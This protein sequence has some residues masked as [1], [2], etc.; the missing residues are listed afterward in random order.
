MSIISTKLNSGVRNNLEKVVLRARTAS[1]SAARNAVRVLGVDQKSLPSGLSADDRTLRVSL[2]AK[3][4]QLGGSPDTTEGFDALVADCA[5]EQW[6]RMLFARF[7][8]ENDLLIHPEGV[9]VT[10]EE[11]DELAASF[12]EPD[13]WM[14]AARFASQMLP[15]IFRLDDPCLRVRL[16]P[17][18]RQALEHILADLDRSIFLADD[19][20]G[21]VYQFW[22]SEKKDEVND[23]G[24]KIAGADLSPVTQLFT[25]PYMVRF[26]LENTL[27]AWWAS[28]NPSSPLNSTFE[29]LVRDEADGT[30]AGG[31][32]SW[33]DEPAELTVIDPACGSGHF[34][35]DVFHL[36]RLM[37]MEREGLDSATAGDAVLQENLYGLELD[38]RCIQISAFAL[39]LGAWRSGGYRELPVPNLACVGLPA[40]G[41]FD[42]WRA[43]VETRHS[44]EMTR[45]VEKLYALFADADSLGSL[46]N[47][48][49]D[50]GLGDADD[51]R[52]LISALGD[53]LGPGGDPVG[54]VFGSAVAESARAAELLARRYTLVATNVP[55]LAVR[56]QGDVLRNYC[57]RR[58]P[59][60]RM[61]LATSFVMRLVEFS[62]EGGAVATVTPQNWLTL[63]SYEPLRHRALDSTSMHL[64]ARLG[65]GAFETISGHVVKPALLVFEARRPSDQ[66]KVY[67]C[68]ADDARTISEKQ[69]L[70][71]ATLQ[72]AL[73]RA[74]RATPDSRIVLP[75]ASGGTLLSTH[76]WSHQ[77]ITSGDTARFARRFWEVPRLGKAWS[78]LQS[79]VSETTPFGGR[80]SILLWEEGKG[81][82]E[83]YARDN[84]DRLHDSHRRGSQAWNHNG[85]AVSQFGKLPVSLYSG[86]LFDSNVAVIVPKDPE[87][88]A[89]LWHFCGS[90]EFRAQVRRIDQKMNVTNATFTKIPFDLDEWRAFADAAGN[91]PAPSSKDVT[92]WL[93]D[94]DPVDSSAPLQVAVARL[95]GY[96]W[97]AQS[98]NQVDS[99]VD[100][101]GIVCLPALSRE[102][103]AVERIRA[104]LAEAYGDRWGAALLDRLLAAEGAPG[105][106]LEEWLRDRFF[107]AH[108]ARFHNRPFIWH[109]S[110]G[111]RDGFSA[112]VNY[113]RLDRRLLERLTYAV[114]GEWLEI[115]RRDTGTPGAD[116]RL[117][118]TQKLQDRLKLILE[119]ESP[120]DIYVRWKP[121]AEQSLG[122][123]P[124]INDGVRLNIRPFIT[125]GVLR[126]RANVSWGKDRG[127]EAD[128]SERINDRRLTLAEKRAALA[129]REAA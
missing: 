75:A 109:I 66:S 48:A 65:P 69:T 52:K 90:S 73:Q 60:G 35:V 85:V 20:L 36:L 61:D 28:R 45:A 117:A 10:L 42:R 107:A 50:A 126:S 58:F 49:K 112:L 98:G 18:G 127:K 51:L 110:D 111:R 16:A 86:D 14:L 40:R 89:A 3:A 67:F 113:H 100:N 34:L 104:L 82:L 119:G 56:K 47:P 12:G 5:Y 13:A 128:G 29:Y 80:E 83:R 118:A 41:N 1:E 129:E 116:A 125:A 96:S 57:A 2:R 87:D 32:Q 44:V 22:Q 24:R 122:W 102:R 93:F 37:R 121:V 38:P 26:L 105:K 33:P 19:A 43:S 15:G 91:L 63:S 78:R 39:A 88:V 53:A 59:E 114:I 108:C 68:E 74:V 70:L 81:Q 71:K 62:M 11:C 124:D 17:E 115:Q 97:P 30:P 21:W 101:D 6:H 7:L 54:A 94:G 95:L 9:P 31:F 103:P 99:F 72:S 84:R 46:L 25:E 106:S 64:V 76:A 92:Q 55:Y 23:S 27:G 77:G 4:R 120:H 123:E 8:A 79:S